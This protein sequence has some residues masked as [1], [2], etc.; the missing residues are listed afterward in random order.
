MRFACEM[1]STEVTNSSVQLQ[2]SNGSN[3]H[4]DSIS[5]L[6][7]DSETGTPYTIS[8]ID[9]HSVS[10]TV[11]GLASGHNFCFAVQ[12]TSYGNPVKSSALCRRTSKHLH[13]YIYSL[14]PVYSL[15]AVTR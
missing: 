2:W 11:S 9:G 10:Y 6:Y 4:I 13:T 14:Y 15:F 5:I 3:S 12:F 7:N 1:T 8:N